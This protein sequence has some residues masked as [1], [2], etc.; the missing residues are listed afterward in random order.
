VF[1]HFF[2]Y[3]YLATTPIALKLLNNDVED[4]YKVNMDFFSE[5]TMFRDSR[6]PNIVQFFGIYIQRPPPQSNDNNN[7]K[8]EEYNKYYIVT[9]LMDGNVRDFLLDPQNRKSVGVIELLK[10]AIDAATGMNHLALNQIIHRD[11]AG[12]YC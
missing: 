7:S 4:Q 2:E 1:L 3:F 8:S 9:E 12:L 10:I 5:A 11:L 6:H